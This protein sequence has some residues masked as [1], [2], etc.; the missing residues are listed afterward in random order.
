M[1]PINLI[2]RKFRE[3]VYRVSNCRQ[4]IALVFDWE[5]KPVFSLQLKHVKCS[6]I[7]FGG[8]CSLS[9]ISMRPSCDQMRLRCGRMK[10][11]AILGTSPG[12]FHP[13]PCRWAAISSRSKSV[14][15]AWNARMSLTIARAAAGGSPIGFR[16]I[17]TPDTSRPT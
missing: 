12:R 9:I 7:I 8:M 10:I 11:F 17:A 14:A 6:Q 13:S 2:D 1:R 5:R 3:Q 16:G 4:N 15:T